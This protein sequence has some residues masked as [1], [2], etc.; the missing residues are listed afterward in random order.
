MYKDFIKSFANADQVL[1][2]PVYSAGEKVK[3]FNHNKF[4]KDI[5]LKSKTKVI[6]TNSKDDIENFFEKKIL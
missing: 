1:V 5:L 3:N 2:C 4:C 6:R